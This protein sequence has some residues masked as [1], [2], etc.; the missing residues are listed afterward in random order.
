MPVRSFW[1]RYGYTLVTLA[2]FAVALVRQ[3]VFG[4]YEYA[5]QQREHAQAVA[6]SGYFVQLMRGTHENWQS[7]F[8]QLV[9]QVAGLPFFIHVGSTQ[10]REGQDRIEEKVDALLSALLADIVPLAA[11]LVVA[12]VVL[13]TAMWGS[14]G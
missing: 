12:A 14:G 10:S 1:S 8:L 7:E 4:W 11:V 3:W 9:W 6:V 5:E 2:L 13:V